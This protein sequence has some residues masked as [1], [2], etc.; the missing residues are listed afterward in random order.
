MGGLY[1]AGNFN[2]KE[3]YSRFIFYEEAAF[4]KTVMAIS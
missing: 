2:I 1:P 3:L 4:H